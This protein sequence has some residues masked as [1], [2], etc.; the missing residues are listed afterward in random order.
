[1]NALDQ[2]AGTESLE[3]NELWQTPDI[4][5]LNGIAALRQGGD[6]TELMRKLKETIFA[7]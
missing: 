1:M 3:T 5:E 6:P 4:R 7:A 2:R